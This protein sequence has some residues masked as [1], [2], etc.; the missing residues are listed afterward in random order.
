VVFYAAVTFFA[1]KFRPKR[2]EC[3][4]KSAKCY[5]VTAQYKRGKEITEISSVELFH[6]L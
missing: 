4:S 6:P 2:D 5:L 3:F 1:C